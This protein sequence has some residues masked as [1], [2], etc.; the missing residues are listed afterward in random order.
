MDTPEALR[1]EM[2]GEVLEIVCAPVR[3]AFAALRGR[4]V[5]LEVQAFGDRLNV[6]VRSARRDLPAV[7]KALAGSGIT[8]TGVRVIRPT[9]ENV[10]ISIL[11]QSKQ[12]E[13]SS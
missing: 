2:H 13:V 6:I 3:E 8:P 9:L 7:T 11:T 5:V 4:D 12:N 10:F 1:G